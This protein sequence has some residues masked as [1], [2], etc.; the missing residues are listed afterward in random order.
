MLIKATVNMMSRM[1]VWKKKNEIATLSAE[2]AAA[3]K[4]VESQ[5]MMVIHEIKRTRSVE[6]DNPYLVPR[7]TK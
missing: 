1:I 2:C 3:I 5:R 7:N 6:R 4:Y